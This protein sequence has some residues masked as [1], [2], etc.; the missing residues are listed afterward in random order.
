MTNNKCNYCGSLMLVSKK[1]NAY[2]SAICWET[3]G[4]KEEQR[5]AGIV[6]ELMHEDWGCRSET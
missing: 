2:C 6:Q 4:Y 5:L 1:G 3:E